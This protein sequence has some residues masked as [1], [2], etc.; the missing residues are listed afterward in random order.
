MKVN[1]LEMN[2]LRSLVGVSR[3]VRVRN[4][5][6]RRRAR[7]EIELASKEDQK[8]V[9]WFGNVERMDEY[10][11]VRRVLKA[12]VSGGRLQGSPRLGWID[13]VKVILGSSGIMLGAA[14][15]CS[16]DRKEWRVLI[17]IL[18]IEFS[19]LLYFDSVVIRPPDFFFALPL[20]LSILT[21]LFAPSSSV[22]FLLFPSASV[23]ENTR[24]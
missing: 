19:R 15:Q 24:A 23:W 13:G 18:M 6:V 2:C 20:L 12:E 14:R 7:I 11:M 4:E 5:E 17:H 10:R 16:K 1:V 8:A 9:R 22:S 3:M 21:P